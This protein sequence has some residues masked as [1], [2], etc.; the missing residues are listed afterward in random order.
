[1]LVAQLDESKRSDADVSGRTLAM[2]IIGDVLRRF[3]RMGGLFTLY[4]GVI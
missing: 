2:R 4:K 1:M 3:V